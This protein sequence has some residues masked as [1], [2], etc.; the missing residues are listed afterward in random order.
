MTTRTAK[1]PTPA[2]WWR[3]VVSAFGIALGGL[4]AVPVGAVAVTVLFGWVG[5]R[6]IR[7]VVE[8]GLADVSGPSALFAGVF[9]VIA[10]AMVAIA[11]V[12]ALVAPIF[13]VLPLTAQGVALRLAGAGLVWRTIGMTALLAVAGALLADAL[14]PDTEDGFPIWTGLIWVL[15]AGFL[16]RVFVEWRWPDRADVP[17]R[18]SRDRRLVRL[19]WVWLGILLVAILGVGVFVLIGSS[20]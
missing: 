4:V 18:V 19:L 13:V 9:L 5:Q 8:E 11:V 15:V 20:G 2:A 6:I 14:L 7:A 10:G 17:V 16:A 3:S 1:L 12:L